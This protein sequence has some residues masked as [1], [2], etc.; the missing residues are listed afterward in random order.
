MLHP[1]NY[2]PTPQNLIEDEECFEFILPVFNHQF[3]RSES[4]L[5]PKIPFTL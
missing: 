3:D 5:V 1:K 4:V 2:F